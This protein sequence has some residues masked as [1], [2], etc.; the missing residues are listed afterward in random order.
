MAILNE[1][2]RTL[3]CKTQPWR[4]IIRTLPLATILEIHQL[5]GFALLDT[6]PNSRHEPEEALLSFIALVVQHLDPQDLIGTI[7]M[8]SDRL[9]ALQI[10]L[11]QP[12]SLT[13]SS[14]IESKPN[15][16]RLLR[17]I[18]NHASVFS[19]PAIPA[20]IHLNIHL[21]LTSLLT[22][23]TIQSDNPLLISLL[24][25]TTLLSDSIPSPI[26]N[27]LIQTL[28]TH[29]IP[30][31]NT[32]YFLLGPSTQNIED[33][34]LHLIS[35]P[36]AAGI[37]PTLLPKDNP[38][39]L[40]GGIIPVLDSTARITPFHLHRWEMVQDATPMIGD[41]DTSL[42]LALFGARKAVL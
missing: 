40:Q 18:S 5:F 31:N 11:S 4:L 39:L 20:S 21:S 1:V 24:N 26:R 41:N 9:S 15:L 14:I 38:P 7:S 13:L 37:D 22:N 34:D 17:L 42:S 19:H 36:V 23:P 2:Q 32:L 30:P 3:D 35:T 10:H 8:Y 12:P 29:N 25:T 33:T 6:A 28:T 27:Q 16:Q